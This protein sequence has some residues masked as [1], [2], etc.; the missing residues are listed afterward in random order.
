MIRTDSTERSEFKH[1]RIHQNGYCNGRI[2]SFSA[3]RT[4][5]MSRYLTILLRTITNWK[6]KIVTLTRVRV[7]KPMTRGWKQLPPESNSKYQLSPLDYCF[8]N[9]KQ[10]W[11]ERFPTQALYIPS[12]SNRL[13]S[14][15]Q[16]LS[17]FGTHVLAKVVNVS[18]ASG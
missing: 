8:R 5:E 1:V 15:N 3:L 14:C 10:Y 2:S 4:L 11:C 13:S 16:T 9:T 7:G 17:S 6:R 18:N 12:G